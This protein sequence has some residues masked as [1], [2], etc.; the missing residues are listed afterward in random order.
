MKSQ[1]ARISQQKISGVYNAVAPLYDIWGMLTESKARDRALELADIRDGQN[2][3]EVAVGTGIAF[4]EIVRRNPNGKNTGIDLSPGMLKKAKHRLRRDIHQ[5]FKLEIGSAYQ[6]DHS[7]NS[8]DLLVNNYMFD[9]I[10]FQDMDKIIQEFKRVLKPDGKLILVNMTRGEKFGSHFYEK[11]YKLSPRLM[12]GCRGVVLSDKLLSN[13][14][15]ILL[16]EYHQQLFFP[17]EVILATI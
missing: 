17:S 6:L 2:I 4:Q 15:Q 13:G 10:P 11:I 8:I 3:L 12:G 7:D 1:D 5:N 14:F 9:L 16:R